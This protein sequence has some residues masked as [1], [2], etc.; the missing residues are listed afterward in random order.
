VLSPEK[1]SPKKMFSPKETPS[2]KLLSSSAEKRRSPLKQRAKSS[3][4]QRSFVS[5]IPRVSGSV[6]HSQKIA[7]DGTLPSRQLY[8][9]YQQ[10]KSG[11]R[12]NMDI[13]TAMII[14][15]LSADSSSIFEPTPTETALKKLGDLVKNPSKL[16]DKAKAKAEFEV[17]RKKL[18]S[19]V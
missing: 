13:A 1:K 14:N 6:K 19:F 15:E 3:F 4:E 16:N 5:K 2:K 7:P 10:R 11:N 18:V 12:L 9:S 8:D 17:S